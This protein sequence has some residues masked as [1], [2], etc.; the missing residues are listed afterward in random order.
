M[1]RHLGGAILAPRRRRT[2][3]N[4][5]HWAEFCTHSGIQAL[6]DAVRVDDDPALGRLPEHLGQ[7]YY[8]HGTRAADVGEHLAGPTDGG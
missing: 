4:G 6:I 5:S 1:W 3:R 2:R 7:P 8:R